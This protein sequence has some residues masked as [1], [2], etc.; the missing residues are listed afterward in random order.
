MVFSDLAPRHMS[1]SFDLII[2]L[3]YLYI[4]IIVENLV[5]IGC[6]MTELVLNFVICW[7]VVFAIRL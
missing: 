4:I 1:H 2:I 7:A 3:L 6:V 5:K